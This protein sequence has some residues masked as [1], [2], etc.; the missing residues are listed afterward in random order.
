[1]LLRQMASVFN[2]NM[3]DVWSNSGGLTPQQV[4]DGF[5]TDA[6]ELCNAASNLADLINSIAPG[7]VD[8][9]PPETLT[10]NSDGSIT[11]GTL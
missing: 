6:A 7:T 5:S 10:T 2:Q 8:E 4:L 3:A 11:V 9:T 1:M